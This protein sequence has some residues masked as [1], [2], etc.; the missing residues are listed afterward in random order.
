MEEHLGHKQ[1]A[2]SLVG[3]HMLVV[4]HNQ[5]GH[6]WVP[7]GSHTAVQDSKGGNHQAGVVRHYML[8][9]DLK[10]VTICFTKV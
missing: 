1:A 6:R 4:A 8:V 10:R 5:A 3:V 7:V 2:H 9:V